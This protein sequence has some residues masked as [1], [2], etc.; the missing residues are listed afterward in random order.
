MLAARLVAVIAERFEAEH[1]HHRLAAALQAFGIDQAAH[2]R[3]LEIG[4]LL[5]DEQHQPDAQGRFAAQIGEQPGQLDHRRGA[6]GVVVGAGRIK[7]AVIMRADDERL[8]GG[9]GRIDHHLDIPFASVHAERLAVDGIAQI[10]QGILD[11]QRGQFERGRM[12]DIVRLAADRADMGF[13]I[14]CDLALPGVERGQGA[15]MGTARHGGHPEDGGD[16]ESDEDQQRDRTTEDARS[17]RAGGEG[18]GRFGRHYFPQPSSTQ[19]VASLSRS[20]ALAMTMSFRI[21]ATSATMGFLPLATRR[22]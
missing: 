7:S 4:R 14:G 21:T 8:R 15:G 13:E 16:G 2:I 22:L 3:G 20:L 12:L 6:G 9:C 1:A 19:M 10:G 18:F 5:V 17:G 11:M